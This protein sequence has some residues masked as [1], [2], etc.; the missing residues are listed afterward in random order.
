MCFHYILR[1]VLAIGIENTKLVCVLGPKSFVLG[2]KRSPKHIFRQ[3]RHRKSPKV[4]KT[5]Y[6]CVSTINYDTFIQVTWKDMKLICILGPKTL[7]WDQK[8][9]K[10]YLFLQTAGKCFEIREN[11]IWIGYRYQLGYIGTIGIKNTEYVCILNRKPPILRPEN[12]PRRYFT[13]QAAQK[14]FQSI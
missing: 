10:M 5:I 1:Y 2:P 3:K 4:V 6:E 11:D 14:R 7:F 12:D 9:A 8:V 13:L